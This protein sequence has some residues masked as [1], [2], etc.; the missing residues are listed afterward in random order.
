MA[1]SRIALPVSSIDD[2]QPIRMAAD[3]RSPRLP[4]EQWLGVL[5]RGLLCRGG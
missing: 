2:G 5:A 4:D 1:Q 3:T